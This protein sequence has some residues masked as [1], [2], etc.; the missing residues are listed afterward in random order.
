MAKAL[1]MAWKLSQM[2]RPLYLS[3]LVANRPL[4]WCVWIPL[5]ECAPLPLENCALVIPPSE[6]AEMC[7]KMIALVYCEMGQKGFPRSDL[8]IT[9]EP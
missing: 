3:V 1:R 4:C 7:L 9:Q 8:M 6:S 2:V 5:G